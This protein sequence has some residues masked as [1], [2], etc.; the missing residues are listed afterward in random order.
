MW[1]AYRMTRYEVAG[2]TFRIGRRS[3]CLDSLL[4]ARGVRTAAFVT[5]FNPF[6]RRMPPPWNWRMQKRL[7]QAVHRSTV[8]E[9]KGTWRNWSEAHLLLFGDPRP[10]IRLARRFRQNAVVIVRLRQPAR[11]LPTCRSVPGL[12]RPIPIG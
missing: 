4:V 5:A 1:R 8:A 3:P 6:S 10:A 7:A 9:G 11:L 12:S 2:V